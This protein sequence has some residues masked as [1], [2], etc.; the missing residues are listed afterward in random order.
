MINL[1]EQLKTATLVTEDNVA[2]LE[3]ASEA[4]SNLVDNIENA[5]KSIMKWSN[6]LLGSSGPFGIT[7]IL[8]VACPVMAVIL[9]SYGV[10]R[11]VQ[12]I[13]LASV[14]TY[15]QSSLH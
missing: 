10:E 12:S 2:R 15:F 1:T 11:M 8:F 9:G 6:L 3:R 7:P 4:T 5:Q 14:G 13:A